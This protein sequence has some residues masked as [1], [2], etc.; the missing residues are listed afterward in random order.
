MVEVCIKWQDGELQDHSRLAVQVS[1]SDQIQICSR[2]QAPMASNTCQHVYLEWQKQI[3]GYVCLQKSDCSN[4]HTDLHKSWS[5][6]ISTK[7]RLQL[8]G[9]ILCIKN[10]LVPK[11][12]VRWIVW[13]R[14]F[15]EGL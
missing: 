11:R 15:G 14:M 8:T 12:T 7:L 10:V 1:L 2:T 3:I 6:Y 9:I 13:W 4:L 5:T